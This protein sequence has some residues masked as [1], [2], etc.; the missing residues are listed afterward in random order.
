L[1]WLLR[2]ADR[3]LDHRQLR[4]CT[5]E[6]LAQSLAEIEAALG[7]LGA[8]QRAAA[9]A[10]D[11]AARLVESELRWAGAL[12]AFSCRF[13]QARLAAG[14]DVLVPALPVAERRALREELA[15][16][17]A[18]HEEIWRARNREGGRSDSVEQLSRV[19]RLLAD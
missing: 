15:P 10:R 12:L 5:A 13:G 6:G 17:V 16:L 1:F 8:A 4:G 19:Q 7:A 18:Q 14:R 9:P 2:F 11:A 3:D